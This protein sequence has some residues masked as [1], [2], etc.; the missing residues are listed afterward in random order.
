VPGFFHLSIFSTTG[1]VFPDI[2]RTVR[3]RYL[4][5]FFLVCLF[6]SPDGAGLR[7]FRHHDAFPPPTIFRRTLESPSFAEGRPQRKRLPFLSFVRHFSRRVAPSSSHRRSTV[8]AA[9]PCGSFTRKGFFLSFFPRSEMISWFFFSLPP[10][11]GVFSRVRTLSTA[12][13]IHKRFLR[14]RPP[15]RRP[16]PLHRYYQ[17]FYSVVPSFFIPQTFGPPLS[18]D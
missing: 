16:S 1:C 18:R 13:A 6:L 10:G 8:P 11:P 2:L 5:F 4:S 15:R 3:P 17:L 9:G 12:T 7:I 14:R